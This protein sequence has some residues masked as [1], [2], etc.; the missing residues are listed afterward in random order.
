MVIHS[1]HNP[2]ELS[3]KHLFFTELM[4]QSSS[5]AQ[6]LIESS[7]EDEDEEEGGIGIGFNTAA[8]SVAFSATSDVG[9][10]SKAGCALAVFMPK[11]IISNVI[12]CLCTI[13]GRSCK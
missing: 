7:P 5:E 8:F 2:V 4:V 10:G 9:A 11:Q 12:I 1:T 13:S 6:N 3:V